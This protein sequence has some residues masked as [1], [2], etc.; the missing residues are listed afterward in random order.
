M[1][2]YMIAG[3]LIVLAALFFFIFIKPG[4]Q[5]LLMPPPDHELYVANLGGHSIL[6][7]EITMNP[8]AV[9]SAPWRTIRGPN[10]GLRN[11]F[12]VTVDG[13]GQIF[14]ANLGDPP[15]LQPSV[16]VYGRDAT[17]DVRPVR[18]IGPWTAPGIAQFARPMGV[19][20]RGS[21]DNLLVADHFVD[22]ANPAR[23]L[24]ARVLEF[25]KIP[26]VRDP[27]GGLVGNAT[28]L[29]G[30]IR[31]AL[32]PRQRIAVAMPTHNEIRFFEPRGGVFADIA[33]MRRLTGTPTLL[34]YPIDLTFDVQGNLYVLNRGTPPHPAADASITVYAPD[35]AGSAP[36]TRR[37]GG[38]FAANTNLIDPVGIAVNEQGLIIVTGVNSLKVFQPAANGDVPPKVINHESISNPVGLAVR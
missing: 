22:D 7:F 5:P 38:P 6:G 35:S 31:L 8:M 29:V 4:A 3:G 37:I 21:P 12:D 9:A 16:T 14:V 30:P 26:A 33:P 19:A 1:K 32:D 28:G 24:A 17:G 13:D 23:E 27:T 36:P 20:L 15:G 25:S 11:P 34:N 18:T 10:T 2:R